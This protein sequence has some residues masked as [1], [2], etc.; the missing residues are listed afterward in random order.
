[1]GGQCYTFVA[2]KDLISYQIIVPYPIVPVLA[3]IAFNF[4]FYIATVVPIGI[5]IVDQ[6][7]RYKVN[8][9]NAYYQKDFRKNYSHF[10][11]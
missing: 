2:N 5:D 3:D 8:Q 10:E 1:M 11:S 6:Q 9:D 4:Y 7:A